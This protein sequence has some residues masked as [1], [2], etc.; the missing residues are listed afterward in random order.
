[1]RDLVADTRRI[2][3]GS[4]SDQLNF[5]AA[6]VP[7]NATE[8]VMTLDVSAMQPGMVLSS[9]LNVYYVIGMVA[10][11][12]RILVYPNYDNSYSSALPAG[13]PVMIR[14]RVTD[15]LLF[16]NVNDT[17]R[18]MSSSTYG[19]YKEGSWDDVADSTW[20]TYD[21]PVQA[22]GM[23]SLLK[24]QIR[25]HGSGDIWLDLPANSVQWQPENGLVRLTRG[26]MMG[27]D[28]RFFY[29]SPFRQ[30]TTLDDDVVALLGLAESMVDIPPLG[31][32][33]ALLRTTESRRGQIHSQGDARRPEEVSAGSNAQAARELEKDFRARVN[34]EYARLVNR[35]PITRMI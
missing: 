17:I 8:L 3:Y 27:S 13:S 10:S 33:V 11:E 35:N 24:V 2:A 18:A 25:Y 9:G 26:Y 31:A 32:A 4:M 19:L 34:D 22:E 1:M 6:D 20:Q 12:K 15:W 21:I 16:N 23:T 5:L 29:R 7:A 28:L 30:A 14:P